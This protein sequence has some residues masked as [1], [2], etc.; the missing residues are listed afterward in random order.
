M[1]VLISNLS[2]LVLWNNSEEL[3]CDEAELGPEEFA[4]KLHSQQ[5]LQE[6][7][8]TQIYWMFETILHQVLKINNFAATRD[9]EVH[10]QISPGWPIC[11]PWEGR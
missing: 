7:V 3:A 6:Q 2:T 10:A 1:G 4:E 11:N 8:V 9:A 5:K